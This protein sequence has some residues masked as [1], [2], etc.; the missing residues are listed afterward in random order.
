MVTAPLDDF[1]NGDFRKLV[2]STGK[3]VPLY[4]PFDAAGNIIPNSVDRPR[5]ECIHDV[6]AL[7]RRSAALS[8]GD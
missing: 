7:K 6:R 3:T 1:R 8:G 4:D 5:L 2:D